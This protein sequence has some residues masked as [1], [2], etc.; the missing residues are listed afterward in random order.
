[1]KLD[2]TGK[3][4]HLFGD[5]YGFDNPAQENMLSRERLFTNYS[6]LIENCIVRMHRR[7][8]PEKKSLVKLHGVGR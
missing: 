4:V 8:H 5:K 2:K 3:A 7:K 6:F 1:M